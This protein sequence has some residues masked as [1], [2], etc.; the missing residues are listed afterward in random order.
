[1]AMNHASDDGIMA[2]NGDCHGGGT[3]LP[4]RCAALDIGEQEGGDAG[5]LIHSIAPR[6]I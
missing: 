2:L 1:M 4:Q 6:G 5:L 3:R